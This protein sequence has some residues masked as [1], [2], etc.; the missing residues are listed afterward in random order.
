MVRNSSVPTKGRM[1]LVGKPSLTDRLQ[2]FRGEDII[3]AV[4]ASS[5]IPCS[6]FLTHAASQ[7][8][9]L[10]AYLFEHLED[11]HTSSHGT[12]LPQSCAH[13]QSASSLH[14]PVALQRHVPQPSRIFSFL[15]LCG[16]NL[17]PHLR[18]CSLNLLPFF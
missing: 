15:S 3:R 2:K 5:E 9:V 4:Q 6:L 12:F 14:C 10:K 1:V 7:T 11:G 13:L 17:I 18:R 16:N 8:S